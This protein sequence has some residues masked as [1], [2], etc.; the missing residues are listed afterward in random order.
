MIEETLDSRSHPAD[1]SGPL[2]LARA[3]RLI[4]QCAAVTAMVAGCAALCGWIVG[5]DVLKSLVP[6]L[7]AM[8]PVT[9]VAFVLLG[10]SLWLSILPPTGRRPALAQRCG[11]V[12]VLIG[13]LKLCDVF[14]GWNSGIDRLLFP[15]ALETVTTGLPNRMAPTTA[16]NFVIMGF[17]MV[18]EPRTYRRYVLG[19]S[20]LMLSAFVS[21]MSLMGYI[22]SISF[23]YRIG[24]F[25]PMALP[26]AL[27]FLVLG[28]GV[29]FA[30]PDRGVASLLRDPGVAGGAASAAGG[31]ARADRSGLVEAGRPAD[32]IV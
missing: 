17:A 26:T 10:L 22:Y 12:V 23:F 31:G 29:C 25:I 19:Q 21:L 16:L 4:P 20:L 7:V 6:G 2:V 30:R 15:G 24:S 27:T 13:L 1:E 14:L 5:N 11:S 28:I 32:R 8:N 3:E 18:L 9:A